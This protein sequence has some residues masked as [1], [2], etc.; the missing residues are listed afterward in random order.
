MLCHLIKK[1]ITNH[2][3]I[4]PIA[5]TISRTQIT[6]YIELSPSFKITYSTR[7]LSQMKKSSL[8]IQE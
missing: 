4:C 5:K 6:S 3:K 8:L 1:D 7:F 2:D